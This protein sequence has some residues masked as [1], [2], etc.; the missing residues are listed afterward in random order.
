MTTQPGT[1]LSE[2]NPTKT[3]YPFSEVFRATTSAQTAADVWKIPKGT[4][5]TRVLVQIVTAATGSANNIIV[6]DDDDDNGFILAASI[7]GATVGTVYGDSPTELGAY[8]AG[9]DASGTHAGKWKEYHAAGK[10]IKIDQS[11]S[12]TTEAVVDIFV[13]G[14]RYAYL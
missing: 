5:I 14:Y 10:E 11:A 1:P 4:I 12:A 13:F 3:I 2:L 9:G 7:C 6:G 8:L